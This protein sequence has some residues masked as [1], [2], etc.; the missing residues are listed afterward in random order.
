M[1]PLPFPVA[2]TTLFLFIIVCCQNSFPFFFLN[3]IDSFLF[4]KIKAA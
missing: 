4:L 3:I 1:A 2:V